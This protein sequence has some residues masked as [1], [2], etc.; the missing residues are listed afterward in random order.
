MIVR[1]KTSGSLKLA[2]ECGYFG[3]QKVRKRRNS[4]I[5]GLALY[6]SFLTQDMRTTYCSAKK[7]TQVIAHIS[8][9]VGYSY[10]VNWLQRV[11]DDI[12]SEP[13][14]ENE[15]EVDG[16]QNCETKSKRNGKRGSSPASESTVGGSPTST[17]KEQRRSVRFGIR[18]TAR[19]VY[20]GECEG[21]ANGNQRWVTIE[22]YGRLF[23]EGQVVEDLE[24]GEDVLWV[25]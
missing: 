7:E 6:G 23:N 8:F 10:P 19:P 11:A 15:D 21:A 17:T 18:V 25:E 13:Q 20:Q 22:E 3:R 5:P 24:S 12:E 4:F 14:H 2:I 16:W 1:F 9:I